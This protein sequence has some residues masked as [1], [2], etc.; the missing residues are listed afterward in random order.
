[1]SQMGGTVGAAIAKG[2][3]QFVPNTI[4]APQG[5]GFASTGRPKAELVLSEDDARS[6]KQPGLDLRVA[7]RGVVVGDAVNIQFGRHG[8]VDLSQERQELLVT[9]A[10]FATS[11]HGLRIQPVDATH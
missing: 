9:M 8:L 2:S 5:R 3:P 6:C 1:M 4:A 11:Q 7:V 10:R